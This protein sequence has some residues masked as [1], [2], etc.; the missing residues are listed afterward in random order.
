[1]NFVMDDE[2][3]TDSF[4]RFLDQWTNT[5]PAA[6]ASGRNPVTLTSCQ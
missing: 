2:E 4:I 5:R 3:S 1:M 6:F